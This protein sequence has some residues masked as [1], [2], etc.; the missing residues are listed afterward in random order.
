MKPGEIKL[1]AQCNNC[2]I[3]LRLGQGISNLDIVDAIL[4]YFTITF[5]IQ[6]SHWTGKCLTTAECSESGSIDE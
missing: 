5:S 4:F 2:V 1:D 3:F 6:V